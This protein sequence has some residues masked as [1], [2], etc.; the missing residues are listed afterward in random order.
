MSGPVGLAIA[1]LLILGIMLWG[2]K[3]ENR[4]DDDRGSLG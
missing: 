4:R 2:L 3:R 1:T